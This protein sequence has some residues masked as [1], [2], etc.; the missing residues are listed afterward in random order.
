MKHA[1]QNQVASDQTP[2]AFDVQLERALPAPDRQ[3]Y[4]RTMNA[5]AEY[6][7]TKTER[8]A[9]RDEISDEA[10]CQAWERMEQE[11]E[12]RLQEAYFFDTSDI[13][14]RE[15]CRRISALEIFDLMY[16]G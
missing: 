4:A 16:P 5:L 7:A 8:D 1:D 11:A 2:L 3:Y 13:H 12:A 6:M 14:D 9:L 15:Q 10:S